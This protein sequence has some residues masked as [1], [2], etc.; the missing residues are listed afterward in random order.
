MAEKKV[1]FY[2]L[3]GDDDFAI[4]QAV[5]EMAAR[6]GDKAIAS[7]NISHFDASAVSIDEIRQVS[8][9]F[10]FLTERRLV[11]VHHSE[12]LPRGKE[13]EQEILG[14]LDELPGTTALVFLHILDLSRT[15]SLDK[16]RQRSPLIAW[17][18]SHPETGFAKPYIRPHG[19]QFAHWIQQ[20][21][22]SADGQIEWEAAQVL[23]DMIGEDPQF[24]SLEMDKLLTY[25]NGE[26]P[27]TT[28][29]VERL[30]PYHGQSDVFA[31]V[32]AIGNRQGFD[33][34]K[35]L[36]RILEERDSMFA[37][38]MIVRQF[39]L[40]TQIRESMELGLNPASSTRIA[41]FLVKRLTPQAKKFTLREL[42]SIIH[43]M[44]DID[45][46]SKSGRVDLDTALYELTAALT[47]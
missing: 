2:L 35:H 46:A 41:P 17:I 27:I 43:Q 37:F 1:G 9:S 20:Y 39:R 42:E 32:D 18:E 28:A 38:A 10:P 16:F 47:G 22:Q 14:L 3:Y 21:A 12:R 36:H 44:L 15:S 45:L 25:T 33:A 5:K 13:A 29:D 24:A 8:L 23:A 4:E 19:A 34:S 7:M 40:L 11:F 6:V 30:T 26:R 31:L